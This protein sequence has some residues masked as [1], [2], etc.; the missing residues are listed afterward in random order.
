MVNEG[1]AP[2]MEW[3][4]YGLPWFTNQL[5]LWVHQTWLENPRTEWRF[6]ARNITYFYAAFS[7]AM[8]DYRRVGEGAS[9]IISIKYV[10]NHHNCH[11][12]FHVWL[13]PTF[14]FNITRTESK[15]RNLTY[16]E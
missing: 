12:V 5:T 13:S 15:Q 9:W 4:E 10:W 1:K 2:M 6:L 8:Y 7:I 3:M 14:L 16:N 11:T